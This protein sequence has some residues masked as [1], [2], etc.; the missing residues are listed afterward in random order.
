MIRDNAKGRDLDGLFS[1]HEN[2][3]SK[4]A[5]PAGLTPP[6]ARVLVPLRT[7]KS[8]NS[9]SSKTNESRIGVLFSLPFLL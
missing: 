9:L 4:R 7:G 3:L 8:G 1:G 2:G 5:A 6:V